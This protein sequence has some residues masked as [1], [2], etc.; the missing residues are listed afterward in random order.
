MIFIIIA[1]AIFT[2]DWIVKRQIDKKRNLREESRILKGKI[3]LRKY[4]NK[5]AVLNF[6][7]RRP[8]VVRIVCGIMLVL[9][10]GMFL[11]LLREKGNRGLKLGAA[12]IIGGGA[13]NLYDRFTK[14][15]VVDYFS[16][17]SRFPRLQRIVFNLSDMFIFLGAMMIAGAQVVKSLRGE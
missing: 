17:K 6:L 8:R 3:I 9:F 16:F 7:E 15:H 5:G 12:M 10:C 13:N 14:G 2:L 1:A 4:Y 11:F